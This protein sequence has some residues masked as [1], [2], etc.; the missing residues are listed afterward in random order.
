MGPLDAKPGPDRFSSSD[1][2]RAALSFPSDCYV[3]CANGRLWEVPSDL[4]GHVLIDAEE[5]DALTLFEKMD[6]AAN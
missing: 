4:G 5:A 6:T 2:I 3:E 1:E